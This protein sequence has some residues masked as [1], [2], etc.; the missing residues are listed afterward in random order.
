MNSFPIFDLLLG[1]EISLG[2]NKVNITLN[3][4]FM[5]MSGKIRVK[6]D[7]TSLLASIRKA[8]RTRKR[9]SISGTELAGTHERRMQNSHH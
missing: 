9:G 2:R 7:R 6:K 1:F 3:M 5:H 8:M 4:I